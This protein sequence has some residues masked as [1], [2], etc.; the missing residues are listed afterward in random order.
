MELVDISVLGTDAK[1]RV[2]SSPTGG[3]LKICKIVTLKF[4]RKKIKK[5][6]NIFFS[7]IIR[8]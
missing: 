8:K 1:R 6:I 5:L 7:K 4:L 3:K 2:G